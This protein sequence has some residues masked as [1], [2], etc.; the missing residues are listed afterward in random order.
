MNNPLPSLNGRS[1]FFQELHI[2]F[3]IEGIRKGNF[4]RDAI[5]PENRLDEQVEGRGRRQPHLFAELVETFL[6]LGFDS[7]GNCR[8]GH[9]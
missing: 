1:A 2:A 9:N 6:V 7:C 3:A 4:E 5:L 8:K